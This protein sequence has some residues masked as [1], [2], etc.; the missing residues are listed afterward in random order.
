[1]VVVEKGIKILFHDILS[2]ILL[3]QKDGE[4]VGV[5][6]QCVIFCYRGKNYPWVK[7]IILLTLFIIFF[8]QHK[9]ASKTYPNTK[10]LNV[11]T[12]IRVRPKTE[13]TL[14]RALSGT[15]EEISSDEGN[16]D[17]ELLK[18]GIE[19][20]RYTCVY[21]GDIWQDEICFRSIEVSDIGL[22]LGRI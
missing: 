19:N 9:D 15:Y 10:I 14:I 22:P 2:E 4:G 3:P 6:P 21:F 12:K 17:Q 1:M 18:V 16:V 5:N 13:P 20:I 11:H 8:F 7:V